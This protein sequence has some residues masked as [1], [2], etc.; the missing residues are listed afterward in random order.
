MRNERWIVPV[1]RRLSVGVLAA[2]AC[3]GA[4]AGVV[5]SAPARA[6]DKAAKDETAAAVR[7]QLVGEWKLNP[8]LSEDPREKMRQAR[9]GGER[10][11]GG[12]SPGGQG[13]WRGGGGSGGPGGGHPG[14][15][16][17]GQRGASGPAGLRAPKGVRSQWRSPRPRSR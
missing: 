6:D 7:Q 10:P 3:A 9:A 13:G 5:F 14:G 2:A 8:E 12:G 17:G 11:E 16:G 4:L 1:T 15:Y